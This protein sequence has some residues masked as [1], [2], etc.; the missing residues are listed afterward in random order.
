M[1]P[2]LVSLSINYCPPYCCSNI[3]TTSSSSS[4]SCLSLKV[5]SFTSSGAIP[6]RL[7]WK[8]SCG[9]GLRKEGFVVRA[10]SGGDMAISEIREGGGSEEE[11]LSPPLIDSESSSSRPRRIALF[12]EPS[13]FA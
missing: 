13:P 2:P 5:A 12:V 1:P 8:R 11:E 10:E 9:F 6:R 4:K 3:P 7:N